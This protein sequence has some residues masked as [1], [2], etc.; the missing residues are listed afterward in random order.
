MFRAENILGPKSTIA[1]GSD[2]ERAALAHIRAQ[3]NAAAEQR[4]IHV[5][6]SYGLGETA[7]HGV[8]EPGDPY[9]AKLIERGEMPL[10]PVQDAEN[11]V[12]VS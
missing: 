5:P 8:L 1:P 11:N 10:P 6:P 7:I 3:R 9:T 4:G 12:A 2:A